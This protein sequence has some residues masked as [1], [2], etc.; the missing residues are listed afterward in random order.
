MTNS[1][2]PENQKTKASATELDESQLDNVEGG[3]IKISGTT[4]KEV[5]LDSKTTLSISQTGNSDDKGT[6]FKKG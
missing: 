2:K 3:Y 1:K 6:G 5:N 4:E